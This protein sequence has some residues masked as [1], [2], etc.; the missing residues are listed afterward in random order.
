MKDSK[1]ISHKELQAAIRKFQKDGGI[2]KKL[3]DQ[4]TYSNQGVGMRWANVEA[5]DL[6]SS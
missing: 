3:P 1:V 2:I 6:P 5:G 4:K